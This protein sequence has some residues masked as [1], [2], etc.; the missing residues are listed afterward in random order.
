M[1]VGAVICKQLKRARLL[2]TFRQHGAVPDW[3][4]GVCWIQH[5]ARRLQ[6]MG[7]E[8]KLMAGKKVKAS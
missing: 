8:V 6:A 3:H 5:W 2:E 4:G 7:H 1:C